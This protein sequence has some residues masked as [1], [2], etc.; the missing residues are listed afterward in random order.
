M[1]PFPFS[2]QNG[3][4]VVLVLLLTIK[5]YL[6]IT[7]GVCKS[8]KRLDGKTIIITGANT[9]IGKE[10]ALDLASRGARIILACRDLKKASIA[11][12]DI[13]QKSGNCNVLVK[14]LDLASLASV[15]QFAEDILKNEPELHILINNAGCGGMKKQITLD[16]LENQMQS[17]HL[18]HFLLTNLLLGL[19]IKTAEKEQENV[20]II[21]VSSDAHYICRSL[22]FEDLNFIHDRTA[23]TFLAPYKIYGTSKLCNILFS[24]ELANKLEHN[25]RAVTVNSLHPGA[26]YTEFGRFSS[27]FST[28][29]TISMYFLKTPKEGAQTTIHL[30]VSDE[31]A[32]V[33]AQYFRDCK[34]ATPSKLAQ[35]NGMAKK[36]WDVSET[37]V[38]LQSH[39]IFF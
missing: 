31:V 23:G 30:A 8:T 9:G 20:R 18:G 24:I 14:K 4:I 25:G 2:F 7:K 1:F 26:V 10:T 3:V 33:T 38:R 27:I 28:I 6:E 39:E 11:K 19:M 34:I 5:L 16:G 37:L 32:N 13:V 21:N 15:R 22:N 12:D 29:M 17:N 35:D 36:L